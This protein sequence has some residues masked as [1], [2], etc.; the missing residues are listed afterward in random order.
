MPKKRFPLFSA[1]IKLFRLLAGMVVFI[2]ALSVSYLENRSKTSTST[3]FLSSSRLSPSIDY[4]NILITRV[5]DGDTLELENKEHVRLI[6]IDT[7]E[8]RRNSK[9][10]KDSKRLT[11]DVEQIVAMGQE[12]KNFTKKLVLNQRG[13]LAFDVGKKD[14]YG[15]LL[16]YVYLKKEQGELFL[17]AAI[18][19]AGYA[20]PMTIPPNVKFAELFKSL[21]QEA[22]HQRR[23]LW[24]A[25]VIAKND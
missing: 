22:R 24:Q 4:R 25:E 15:R 9:A 10:F 17:N 8:S 12:A 3:P 6:G 13:R 20:S 23:G 5:I 14:K 21:Y 1:E 2:L 18:I 7:P 16:A 11:T 19:K